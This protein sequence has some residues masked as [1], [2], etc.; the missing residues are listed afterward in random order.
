MKVKHLEMRNLFY[1]LLISLTI[2]CG[3]PSE[4]FVITATINGAKWTSNSVTSKEND[5]GEIVEIKATGEDRTRLV[6]TMFDSYITEDASDLPLDSLGEPIASTVSFSAIPSLHDINYQL[7]VFSPSTTIS[8]VRVIWGEVDEPFTV[9]DESVL[10]GTYNKVW[11]APNT[12]ASD[13]DYIF[14][15]IEI[16]HENG[17][18]WKSDI[19]SGGT[20][21][22]AKYDAGATQQETDGEFILTR[23]DR[24]QKIIAGDFY[25][26]TQDHTISSGRIF[27]YNY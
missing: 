2:S 15:Q 5:Y 12:R 9:L 6:F 16:V 13:N 27:D 24:G 25:F 14:Y 26:E 1:L 23:L 18:I 7:D 19:T 21:F 11:S 17:Q 3:G 20:S 4:S 8:E 10:N 22:R